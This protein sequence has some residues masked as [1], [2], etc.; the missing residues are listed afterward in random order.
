[1]TPIKLSEIDVSTPDHLP[2]EKNESLASYANRVANAHSIRESDIVGGASFGGMI[3]AEIAQQRKSAGLILLGSSLKPNRLPSSYRLMEIFGPLIPDFILGFR[4]WSPL[5]RWRFEPLSREAEQCLIAMAVDCPTSQ[6]REFGRMIV[7]WKGIETVGCPVLSIHGDND[8]IIP[9][10][11]AEPGK[12][13]KNA[14]HAFTLTH[15]A[16]TIAEIR[17]FLRSLNATG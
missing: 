12:I 9:L 4:S 6:I 7:G 16:E 14:G 10:H 17:S 2:P 1:M 3:A 13:I 11:A 15:T 8:K 5:V